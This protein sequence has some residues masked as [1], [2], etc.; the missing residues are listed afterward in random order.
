MWTIGASIDK[1][2]KKWRTATRVPLVGIGR[3]VVHSDL[4]PNISSIIG[5]HWW[6]Q[7]LAGCNGS[8]DGDCYCPLASLCAC[9]YME[10]VRLLLVTTVRTY[11]LR[12]V[13]YSHSR[14]TFC[15]HRECGR[16]GLRN[17]RPQINTCTGVRAIRFLGSVLATARS[18][19]STNADQVRRR[20]SKNCTAYIYMHRLRTTISN[21]HT[22]CLV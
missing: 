12:R 17:R 16:A 9:I 22:R 20:R 14:P 3:A 21:I 4:S 2:W 19:R 13:A 6:R 5:R 1:L 10:E 8:S 15:E 7:F 18:V 11:S